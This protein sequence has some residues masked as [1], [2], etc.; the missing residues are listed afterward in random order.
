MLALLAF[1]PL[2]GLLNRTRGGLFGDWIR[3]NI[4]EGYGTQSGRA[5]FAIGT[6]LYALL[7]TEH[8]LA[9]GVAAPI[10][11]GLVMGWWK[12][13]D[14]GRDGDRSRLIEGLIMT[15]RGLIMTAP[16]GAYLWWLGHGYGY[17]FAGLALGLC[18]ELGHRTPTIGPQWERGMPLGEF[19]TGC[20]LWIALW[21]STTW[22][23]TAV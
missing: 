17:A 9:I 2:G 10:F 6:A 5:V 1:A 11:V 21:A 18:Y 13:G 7:L 3:A 15:G 14:V 22:A 23:S 20:W 4:F 19:Y 8:A 12:S 16:A